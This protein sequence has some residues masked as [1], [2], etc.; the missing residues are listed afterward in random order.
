[1]EKRLIASE[2][3]LGWLV[4]VVKGVEIVEGEEAVLGVNVGHP[5]ITSGD[6]VT[7]TYLFSAVRGGDAAL[8]KLRWDFLF[9]VGLPGHNNISSTRSSQLSAHV[10]FEMSAFSFDARM[11]SG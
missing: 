7:V 11:K 5:I 1:M 4:G 8:P 2:C 10:M 3:R 6:S 9:I